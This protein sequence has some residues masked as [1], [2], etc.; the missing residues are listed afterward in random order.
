MLFPSACIL[1]EGPVWHEKRN[2]VFWVDIEN[3]MLFEYHWLTNDVN[4]YRFTQRISL[5]VPGEGDELILGLQGGVAR[6][7]LS[8]RT[9][10][11]ITGLG[12]NWETHRCNDGIC[13]SGGGLWVGAMELTHKPGTGTL[14]CVEPGKTVTKKIEHVTISNGMAWS[15]DNKWLYYIDSTTRKI[16]RYLY[17]EKT[18]NISF[19]KTVIHIK[20]PIMPDG[21]T[22]DAEG[23]LWVALWGGFGVARYDADSG[24]MIGF[25]DVPAPNVTACAFAGEELD[26]LV[27]TTAQEGMTGEDLVKYPQS[28]NTF[29]ARPGV[30]GV[31]G[32]NCAL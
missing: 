9:L 5:A 1:G 15:G 23:M 3:C 19:D 10:E 22:I 2:S 18:G 16:D 12:E 11:W 26:S 21:M 14:Y 27:I 31:S 24:E 17:D 20:V 7:I 8:S 30:K 6:Y 4:K 32:F 25:I 28:G 13:D 29:V